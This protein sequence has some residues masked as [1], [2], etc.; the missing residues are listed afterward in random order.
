[1]QQTED[2]EIEDDD[3]NNHSLT[4]NLNLSQLIDLTLPE[5]VSTNNALFESAINR[6]SS[7]ERTYN[8][9]NKDYDLI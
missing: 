7:H 3:N 6:L 1:M 8:L 5:F 9:K 4:D 2:S